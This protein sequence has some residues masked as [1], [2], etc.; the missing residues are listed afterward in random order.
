MAPIEERRVNSLCPPP[1]PPPRRGHSAAH[2][3]GMVS[4]YGAGGGGDAVKGPAAMPLVG[5]DVMGEGQRGGDGSGG[6]SKVR[7]RSR[8]LFMLK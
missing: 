7:P 4:A 1:P 2:R 5:D 8:V 3:P 6:G